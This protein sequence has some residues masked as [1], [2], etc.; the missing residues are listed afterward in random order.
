MKFNSILMQKVT[1]EKRKESKQG[2]WKEQAGIDSQEIII[3]KKNVRDYIILAV[4]FIM[5][6]LIIM[7]IFI[8]LVTALNPT[9]RQ[10]ITDFFCSDLTN[11]NEVFMMY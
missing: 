1:E 9:S 11:L 8:G 7:L 2:K 3:K 5:C 10:V 6:A 4:H